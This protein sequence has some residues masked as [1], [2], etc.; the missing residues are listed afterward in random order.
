MNHNYCGNC[1]ERL[2]NNANFCAA[3]GTTVAANQG[4]YTGG[5]HAGGNYSYHY[6]VKV[7]TVSNEPGRRL[8]FSCMLAYIPMLFWIPLLTNPE[9]KT[10]RACANQGLWLTILS[11]VFTIALFF[12]CGY[13]QQTGIINF[14]EITELFTGWTATNWPEKL[15]AALACQLILPFVLYVPINSICGFFHGMGS[16][17]PYCITLF[18]RIRLIK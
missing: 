13:L 12:G 9:D 11:I 5:H 3:C 18:G 14:A 2:K 6:E 10:H 16:D 4:H 8:P 17:S 7:P 1:G 15:P